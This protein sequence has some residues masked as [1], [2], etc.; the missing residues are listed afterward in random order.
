LYD[1]IGQTFTHVPP[2]VYCPIGQAIH[3]VLPIAEVSPSGQAVHD[4][5]P[6]VV[7]YVSIGQFKHKPPE[8]E[9]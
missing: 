1:F 5:L 9:Y 6:V 8:Y 2:F 3:E 7:E 4:I